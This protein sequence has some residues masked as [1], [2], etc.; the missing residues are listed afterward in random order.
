MPD[1]K[2]AKLP[3]LTG[4][5]GPSLIDIR[6]L[7]QQTGAFTFD[8][9]FMATGSCMSNITFI[10]G[11]KGKLIH[12][13]YNIEEL[14]EKSSYIELCYLLLYG[15]LPAKEELQKFE[16]TVVREMTVHE[17]LIDF[18]KGF[19]SGAHPMAIM[20]GVVGALSSFM[21]DGLDIKDPQQRELAVIRLVAK[22]PTLAAIAFRTACGLPIVYPKAEYSYVENLL[23]MMFD[24]PL[25][26]WKIHPKIVRAIDVILM[27]HADHEQN[28]STSTVRIAG[29]SLANPF[30]CIAAG[31][32]SLW[33]PAHG[34][35]N[36]AVL[37][38][39]EEIATTDKIPT[40]IQ[41][42]KDKN[43]PFRLMGFGH[44]VYKNFDPRAKIMQKICYDVVEVIGK[45]NQPLLELAIELEKV[46]LEDEYF[47]KRKLYPNVD[48]YTGI[49]YKSIG[50]PK[51]MF[52]VMFA[53]ARTI[54]WTSQWF[55]MTSEKTIKLGR[56]RQLFVGQKKR[57]VKPIEEREKVK[58]SK[59]MEVTHIYDIVQNVNLST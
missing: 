47:V 3:I 23:Y 38:M 49:V 25:K 37:N 6:N 10:D 36:E 39:L 22:M 43:D 33:G 19:K 26:P 4:T 51:N 57:T 40:F 7:Y 1:G 46:A 16:K 18:Y 41:K 13:G 56:P 28:A 20:V 12:R 15:I 14:C 9:G 35:A 24:N 30:A 17:K 32:A 58:K 29:S 11:E 50:I 44:R 55:E 59:V 45:G 34:G 53:V 52:T 21:H 42:A 48:F 27:L 8:P 31:I 54:G 2:E 5:D